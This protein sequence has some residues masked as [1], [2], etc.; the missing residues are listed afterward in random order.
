MVDAAAPAASPRRQRLKLL[1]AVVVVGVVLWGIYYL[2][3]AAHRVSTDNAYVGA[4]VAQVTPLISG[5]VAQVLVVETQAVAAGQPLVILDDADARLAVAEAQA[6]LSQAERKVKA[7]YA[8][9]A[10]LAGQLA[11]HGADIARADAVLASAGADFERARLDL[12]RRQAL[13]ASGAVSGDELSTAQNHFATAQAAVAAARAARAQA[14][15]NRDAAIGARA[16]NAANIQGVSADR[17]PA[18]AAA[19]AR[20]AAAE[21]ALKRTVLSAPIAGVVSKRNVQIGQQVAAGAPLMS[22]VPT[23]RAFV[24]ANYKEVQLEKV[25]PGQSVTLTSDLYGGGVK[26]HGKVR[27]LSGG[28]GAAFSLIPAQNAS[29]NWIKVV[30]RVPVRIDLDPEELKTHPLRVGLSMRAVIDTASN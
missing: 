20:L 19:R 22:I 26:F 8:S 15:A 7:Y 9:D 1:A 25:R 24:D 12:T 5:P 4:E 3:F 29:G 13:A 28:T 23:A 27:G 6:A 17:N 10:A 30:Q 14:L 16:V 11:A 2:L 18:V 21:L